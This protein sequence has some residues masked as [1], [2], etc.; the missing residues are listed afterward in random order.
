[1]ANSGAYKVYSEL[2]AWAKGVVVIG[3]IAIVYFTGRTIYKGIAKKA[4]AKKDSQTVKDVKDEIKVNQQQGQK[5][6]YPDS[7]YKAWA[8]AIEKAFD[9]CD[10]LE[11]AQNTVNR[12]V[13]E[14]KN[15]TDWLKLVDAYGVRTY[16]QCGWW[17]GSFTGNLYSAISDELDSAEKAYI[18]KLLTERNISYKVS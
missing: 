7:Q 6:T 16:D 17:M 11:T 8:D 1:M 12:V 15:N 3:G 13:R 5:P 10:P 9:G 14:L 4:D 2:P 18:N